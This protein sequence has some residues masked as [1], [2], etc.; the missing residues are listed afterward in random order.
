MQIFIFLQAT[1][2]TLIKK[3]ITKDYK[4]LKYAN[5][6][7]LNLMIKIPLKFDTIYIN[8]NYIQT[9]TK[10][11]LVR[12]PQIHSDLIIPITIF[13]L[14][15]EIFSSSIIIFIKVKLSY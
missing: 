5:Q 10:A 4:H 1:Y 15:F 11:I 6:Q 3:L 7:V 9:T 8:L 13:N 12:I 14:Y 2:S